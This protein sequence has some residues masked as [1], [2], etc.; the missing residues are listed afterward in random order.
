MPE[1]DKTSLPTSTDIQI[2]PSDVSTQ[3][4][5][6]VM[7]KEICWEKLIKNTLFHNLSKK[8]PK[9]EREE[10]CMLSLPQIHMWMDAEEIFLL[11]TRENSS[12]KIRLEKS[13][14]MKDIDFLNQK[15]TE[16]H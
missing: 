16:E 4:K 1:E 5:Y 8:G 12:K 10:I 3:E 2:I 13:T 15:S 11:E 7:L 9:Q 14:D 6:S